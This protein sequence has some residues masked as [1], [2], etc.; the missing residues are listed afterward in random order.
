MNASALLDTYT[1]YLAS[2]GKSSQTVKAYSSDIGA[3][4]LWWEQTYGQA[5]DANAITP[6]DVIEYRAYLVR[7]GRK[8]TTINR[9]LVAL[10]RFFDWAHRQEHTTD[11]PF[12]VLENYRIKQQQGIAPKWLDAKQQ[13][14]LLRE[15]R[16]RKNKRDIAM[17][18]T[19]IRAGLRVSE[20]VQL[21]LGDVEIGE[22]AGKVVVRQ[23]KGTKYREVPLSKEVRHALDGYLQ[24]RQKVDVASERLF[25]GQR[26][27]MGVRG[28]QKVVAKYAY[29]AYIENVTPHTLR[30]TF[31]KNLTDAGVSL[32][33]IAA[34][35]GHESLETVRIYIS[36]SY[37]DLEKA[38][39]QGNGEIF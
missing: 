8:P 36:P 18:Q 16:R 28:V 7:L 33:K 22:R 35:M 4:S 37:L 20:L 2:S 32:E 15:V 17:I 31:G 19:L 26:G 3:F 23:G 24:E 30:H 9:R 27:P 38:V 25:L 21:E 1:D 29:H 14:A 5:F 11:S 13:N 12:D 34:L 6:R 10:R 39:R